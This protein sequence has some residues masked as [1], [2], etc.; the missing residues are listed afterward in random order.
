ML[1]K[2]K[3]GLDKLYGDRL[4]NVVLFGSYARGNATQLS[5]V[6]VLVVLKDVPD[7]NVESDRTLALIADLSLEFDTLISVLFASEQRFQTA[8]D[9]LMLNVRRDGIAL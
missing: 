2:L 3:E 6:D 1:S 9:P 8:R 4:V 5:D 7:R